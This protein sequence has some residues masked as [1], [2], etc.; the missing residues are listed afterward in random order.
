MEYPADAPLQEKLR[1]SSSRVALT[2][3]LDRV[4]VFAALE[5]VFPRPSLLDVQVAV[6]E[7]LRRDAPT[8]AVLPEAVVDVPGGRMLSAFARGYLGELVEGFLSVLTWR[9]GGE[10]SMMSNLPW[11]R[12]GVRDPGSEWADELW[13]VGARDFVFADPSGG[14]VFAVIEDDHDHEVTVVGAEAAELVRRAATRERG[15]AEPGAA[16]DGGAG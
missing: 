5:F 13:R 12:V 11:V 16:A 1:L 14:R 9:S 4:R 10:L 2:K 8:L 15:Q 7:C 6:R 3:L